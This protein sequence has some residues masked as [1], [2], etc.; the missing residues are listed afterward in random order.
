[1]GNSKLIC[2]DCC[3]QDLKM[4]VTSSLME[5][6]VSFKVASTH[7]LGPNPEAPAL[8][9]SSGKKLMI[10]LTVAVFLLGST[11]VELGPGRSP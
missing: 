1:M 2:E 4:S 3:L 10:S 5:D 7:S 9:L 8:P 11:G 6:T